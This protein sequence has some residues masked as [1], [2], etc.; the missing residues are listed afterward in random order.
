MATKRHQ[1]HIVD[2]SPWPISTAS[3]LLALT[4]GATML[5]HNYKLAF[6]IFGLGLTGVIYC[7]YGWW[8]DVIKEG[9]KDLA[10]TEPVRQGLRIGMILFILSEVMFFVSFFS[11]FFKFSFF[12]VGIL[13]GAW[14]KAAGTWP[15][16]GIETFDPWHIPFMNTL[17]LLLSGTTVTWAHYA[18]LENNQNDAAEALLYTILL[19]IFFTCMQALEYSHAPF[20]FKDGVYASNFYMVTGFHGAHVIIGNI[21]LAVCY[22]RVKAGHF[23]HNNGH[24]GFE[25]AAWYWHFVDVVWL[26]LFAFVYVWGR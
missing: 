24:L 25:F 23:A 22:F 4:I 20:A 17:V 21:F 6:P 11:S 18:I 1:Y 14:V 7:A 13:D 10:H 2:L 16:V 3:A 26:F 12:P 8:R 9:I 5:M 19:G 15:P